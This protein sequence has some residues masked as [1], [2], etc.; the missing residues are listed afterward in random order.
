MGHRAAQGRNKPGAPRSEPI[1]VDVESLGAGGAGLARHDGRVIWV[2]GAAPGDRLS[3]LD[4]GAAAKGAQ[5]R[6][7]RVI[8]PGPD[9]VEPICPIVRRC[10]GCDWMHLDVDA[11]RREHARIVSLGI[12]HALG[13]PVATLPAITTHAGPAALAYRT[14]A[15]LHVRADRNGIAVGYRAAGTNDLV[16]IES[17]SVLAEPLLSGV[18]Q[19]RKALAG[20]RGDGDASLA[21]GRSGGE[22]RPVVD[23]AWEGELS[24]ATYGAID[25]HVRAGTW[26]GAR[27]RLAEVRQAALFGDPSPIVEGPDG[28]PLTIAPGGFAQPSD[29]GAALLARRVAELAAA[30]DSG[31]REARSADSGQ[32]VLELYSGSGTLSV[33]LAKGAASFIGV[34]LD[35]AAVRAARKSFEARSLSGKHVVADAATYVVPAKVDLVVLDPPRTGAREACAAIAKARPRRVVY[36]SCDVATLARDLAILCGGR[37]RAGAAVGPYAIETIETFEIFPQTSHVE[38]VVVLRRARPGKSE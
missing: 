30:G 10:G 4:P 6:I 16:S 14:R 25:A 27:V 3:I 28:A 13:V 21:L 2:R 11:Q 23:L 19:L 38:T 29:A 34:E 22:V 8:T 1:E 32:N 37:G 24:S 20:S 9:R 36:V 12:S 26:A 15:R 7:L 5:A 31:P 33:L 35:E 18:A 17:C